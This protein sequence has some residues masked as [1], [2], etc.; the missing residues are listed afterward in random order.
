MAG[1]T[2]KELQILGGGFNLLPPGDKTPRTDLLLAQNW[3]VDRVGK[4]VSRSGY[5]LKLSISGPAFAHSAAIMGGVGGSFYI[6]ANAVSGSNPGSIYFYNGA[7][8]SIVSGLSGNR[9]GMVP[10]NGWM[11]IMDSEVQGRHDG[12]NYRAWGPPLPPVNVAA[13]IYGDVAGSNPAGPSGAYKFYLT[14]QTTDLQFESNPSPSPPALAVAGA[15]FYFLGIPTSTDPQVGIRNLYATGG[16]L[17]QAY[18]IATIPDNTSTAL[19]FNATD[20]AANPGAYLA[21]RWNDLSATNNG[22]VMPADHDAPPAGAGL[23]GPYLSRLFTWVGNRLFWT[24]ANLPQYWPGSHDNAIGNWVDVGMDGEIIL[25]VTVH[26]NFLLIY[27]ERSIWRLQGDPDTGTLELVEDGVGLISAFAIA[28]SGQFD[29]FVAP[30]GL[31]MASAD[32]V[33]DITG[34]ILPLFNSSIVGLGATSIPGSILPGPQYLSTSLDAYSTVLGCAMGKL[35]VSYQE[36]KSGQSYL[37]LVMD[38]ASGRWMYHRSQL[39]NTAAGFQGFLFDGVNMLGLTGNASN[40]ASLFSIDDFRAF[41]ALDQPATPIQCVY[42][43]HFEDAGLPD[44]QK[45]WLEVVIDYELTSD[46]ASIWVAYDNGA[47][48]SIGTITGTGTRKQTSFTLRPSGDD[49]DEDDDGVLAKNISAC[50]NCNASNPVVV[51]NVYLYYYVEARLALAASTLPSDL[52][53]PKVKQCKELQLDIDAS[54]GTVNGN[55]YSDLPGNQLLVRTSPVQTVTT[56]RALLKYPFAAIEGYLWRVAL[57]AATGPFRL[58]GARMLMRVVGTYIEA[59]EA[60]AGFVWDSMEVSFESLMTRIPRAYGIALAAVPIKQFRELS[61]EIE[62]FNANVTATFLTD[63]PGNA[64]ASRSTFTVN[65]G[66]AGRRF[67]R[68]VLAAGLTAAIEGR[69]CRLQLSGSSKFILY[70]A[71]VELLAVGVYI[72]AYEASGGAVYDSREIDF[73]SAKPKEFRE[74]ELDID[75]ASAVTATLYSDLPSPYQMAQIFQNTAVSTTGRQKIKLPVTLSTAPYSYPM[76]R[77]GRL[78]ISGTHAF[79]LYGA[80]LKLREFGTYLTGDEAGASPVGVWD[81]TPLDFETERLKEYKKLEFDIQTDG[82]ATL[83]IWTD[84]PNGALTQQFTTTLSTGG[85]RQT[86]KVP[87]T[88]GIRGRLFQAEV[89]GAGVRLFAGRVWMR[90]LNEPK[91]QWEWKPLPIEPTPPQWS[92]APFPVNP[93]PPGTAVSDPAQWQWGKFLEVEGTPNEWT[94]VDLPFEVSG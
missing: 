8:T 73:G 65:T 91:A 46:T 28:T 49:A 12:T 58:Y 71:A 13:N 9:V 24:D 6:A 90:D 15:D 21:P 81:S 94:W 92:W 41:Y 63:L 26:T 76:G 18:L 60:A 38:E 88:P 45:A 25:W 10:Q 64:Q 54:G 39:V 87:L 2:R 33:K 59:Y 40:L 50:V 56:G 1:Y 86:V 27:K 5:P 74:L 32:A 47:L 44:N 75:A 20:L 37:M 77:M 19:V 85:T 14:Y 80:K 57:K 69:L 52:G 30:N 55:I 48:N 93:T 53:S 16:T 11:W 22:V 67:F 36:Q 84:Q 79:R 23:A 4:L 29:Y 42:Q 7:S 34:A 72:E 83:T 68:Q 62:T 31:K 17:G 89:S 78:I 3:R 51:H 70:D 35:Y 61:L 82:T 66:T 43:S